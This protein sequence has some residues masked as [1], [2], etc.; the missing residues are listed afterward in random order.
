MCW[1]GPISILF[2]CIH[3]ITCIIIYKL[4]PSHKRYYILF[5]LFY[6]CM[7][8]LQATQWLVGTS[9]DDAICSLP[10]RILTY[11]AYILIWLQPVLFSYI[12]LGISTHITDVQ[13]HIYR[14]S[15]LT[16]IVSIWNIM[17]TYESKYDIYRSNYGYN[18]CTY[19]GEYGH[20]LWKFNVRNIDLQPTYYV[21]LSL[22]FLSFFHMKRSSIK[23]IL[24]FSWMITFLIAG[25]QVRYGPELPSFWCYLTILCD[26]PIILNAL[27]ESI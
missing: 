23:Y 17:A 18:T 15:I 7:E 1:T 8:L 5:C 10:N 6:S 4:N 16:L 22:C 12:S 24:F 2:T 13:H 9:S 3:L 26:I 27:R 11:G 19:K 25:Y 14:Y 21:Y 20:L